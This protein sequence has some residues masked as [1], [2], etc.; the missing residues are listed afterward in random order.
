MQ[1]ACEAFT[2]NLPNDTPVFISNWAY[3]HVSG[4][5]NKQN[6]LKWPESER[7]TCAIPCYCF[8][9][10]SKE[11]FFLNLN[12]FKECVVTTRRRYISHSRN[13]NDSCLN[14][15]P[16]VSSLRRVICCGENTHQIWHFAII[17][18]ILS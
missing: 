1:R 6:L 3:F 12:W 18:I 15:C 7:T 14:T 10:I 8:V 5:V 9:N 4:S 17:F 2:K 11:I 16:N 13:V